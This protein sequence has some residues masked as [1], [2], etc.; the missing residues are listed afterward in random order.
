MREAFEGGAGIPADPVFVDRSGRRRRLITAFG[1]AFGVVLAMGGVLLAAG[2]MGSSP[3]P[4]PG[5]P[6]GGQRATH[7]GVDGAGAQSTGPSRRASPTSRPGQP[8]GAPPATSSARQSA[9]PTSAPAS[10]G[11]HDKTHPG[12]N[13]P[14]RST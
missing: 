13:R 7:G 9:T 10:P 14:S 2:L 8:A 4:L 1:A 12:N 11:K 5:L 3:V 6:Q